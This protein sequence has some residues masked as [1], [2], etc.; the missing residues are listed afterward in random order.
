MGYSGKVEITGVN[1]TKLEVLT[2]EEAAELFKKAKNGD[3]EARQRLINGNLRLVL[4]IIKRF[5]YKNESV[6]DLFQVGCIGLIKGIDNFD[7]SL[8]V[9]PSTYL[10]P[11]II[12]EIRR[13][14]RDNNFIRVSRSLR[15]TAYK[16]LQ[17]KER[18]TSKN[19]RE[20]SVEEIA[21]ELDMTP[22]EVTESLEAI[23]DP[24]SLFEPVYHNDGDALYV[25]DQMSD[26]K[27]TDSIWLDSISLNE[28]MNK[29]SDR[30]K[31]ILTLRFFEGKTQ[32]EV[33]DEIG[34][35]QAQ[36]SRLEKSALKHMK[37]Y[38]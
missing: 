4:S 3:I 30:E 17:V 6:D 1:T 24:V 22:E 35:S 16:A 7:T 11:M 26:D 19:S 2:R 13:Y 5:D 15:D 28:A 38:E 29:L 10:V 20:P 37:K 8:N 31:K 36:V 25:M 27:E 9:L 23:Q 32:M 18:L 14:L 33:S 34:I 21:K 12:G